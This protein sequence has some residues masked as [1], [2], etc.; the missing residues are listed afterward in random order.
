M[1]RASAFLLFLLLG[2]LAVPLAPAQAA[3]AESPSSGATFRAADRQKIA[4]LEFEPVTAKARNSEKGRLVSEML[5]T[6]AVNSG[7][8]E[9][10]ER[11]IISR[12]LE[13]LEFG[14]R[15]L[16]YTSAALKVGAMAGATAIV[17]GSVAEEDGKTRIDARFI[18]V[19]TGR[20]LW[21]GVAMGPASLSGI[22]DATKRL[23]RDLAAFAD[24]ARRQPPPAAPKDDDAATA[25]PAAPPGDEAPPP[26]AAAEAPPGPG[27][28]DAAADALRR[29]ARHHEAAKTHGRAK[30]YAKAEKELDAALALAP[31][32][33][34]YFVARGH[35]RYFLGRPAEALADYDQ[36]LAAGDAQ[37]AVHSMR[38]L[39]LIAL[40][41]P[42]EALSAY[43]QAVALDPG[44]PGLFIRRAKL[45]AS[46]GR[47]SDMCR[48]LE[49]AC[50]LGQCPPIENAR[51]EGSCP[52]AP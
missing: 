26:P 3:E 24:A 36:A 11:R 5:T 23:F 9:V 31:G 34:E 35:A 4:I 38:G 41:R 20:I 37:A 21:A 40:G 39:C 7:R 13:E 46:L 16:T 12:L 51:K 15:G 49:A 44:N 17:S 50:R 14:E 19:E 52:A 33:A 43:D 47:P 27:V 8:F 22:S 29:A 25:P 6:A 45:L 42:G 28:T 18:D 32:R 30:R 2:L 10:V 48:D 1:P